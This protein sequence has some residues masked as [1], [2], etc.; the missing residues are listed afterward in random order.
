[1]EERRPDWELLVP[2]SVHEA[3]DIVSS[4]AANVIVTDFGFQNGD[5]AEWLSLWQH[6]YVVLADWGEYEKLR[7]IV[8]IQTSEFVIR[9]SALRHIEFL[10]VV[11]DK[12][13]HTVESVRQH[14]TSLRLTEE[15]YIRLVNALPDIV[16]SL[17]GDGRFA[18]INNSIKRL[19]YEPSEL[20]SKHF[21]EILDESC[22]PN[23]SSETVLEQYR[24][25]VTGADGAPKLFDERR[26][27]DRRTQDL[28]V[29][30]K[31][32][33]ASSSDSLLY[34]AVIS[35]GEINAAGFMYSASV[36]GKPGSVGIIRDITRR[37]ETEQ[38]LRRNLSEKETLLAEIHHRVK[39]NL[40]VISSLLNLQSGSVTDEE[41]LR[42][43][44]DAQIQIQS[45]ALVHEH[46]YQSESF[47]TVDIKQY[48]TNLC[49]NLFDAFAVSLTKISL[50]IEVDPILVPMEQA[51]PIALLINEI[52]SNSIKYAFPGAATGTIHISL[53]VT[54]DEIVELRIIDD[55]IGFPEGKSIETQPTLGH[56]LVYG[57]AGQLDAEAEFRS[58]GGAEFLMHFPLR[59]EPV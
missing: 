7:E 46:L 23:V 29:I 9:D 3:G 4:G 26:T 34:G 40:Q 36:T 1:M 10:P 21:S 38:L 5:F 14:N 41:A 47:S 37:K 18:Y 48:I 8:V 45:M 43:F 53:K 59:T 57:L 16:Y 6:P 28:E 39:N 2:A 12:V 58:N 56:S 35:Y 31:P 19:G 27:G 44:A 55:G 33:P 49:R 51:M 50:V 13:L 22:V 52:V 30:L 24:G 15:R 20:I 54:D 32:G 17:D 42:R 25:R 11:I